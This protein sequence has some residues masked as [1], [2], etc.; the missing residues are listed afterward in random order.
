MHERTHVEIF[1][2]EFFGQ[3]RSDEPG[4][5][6]YQYFSQGRVP[7][8]LS[9]PKHFGLARS[10]LKRTAGRNQIE[11]GDRYGPSGFCSRRTRAVLAKSRVA[12]HLVL[13]E[14]IIFL[15]RY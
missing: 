1:A 2:Y 5:A 14:P 3:M 9:S 11:R 10:L 8:N 4:C 7:I 12:L 6:G 13:I 15:V